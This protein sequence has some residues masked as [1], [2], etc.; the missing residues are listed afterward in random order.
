MQRFDFVDASPL[1]LPVFFVQSYSA[2]LEPVD[3]RQSHEY[4]F[5]RDDHFKLINYLSGKHD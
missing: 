4:R 1:V 2:L 5:G 3:Y